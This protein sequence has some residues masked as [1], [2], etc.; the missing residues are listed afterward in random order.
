MKLEIELVPSTVWFSNVRKLVPKTVWDMIRKK[1]YIVASHKCQIC[2]NDGI[3]HCHEIWEYDDEKHI[4]NLKGFVALCENCHMIKHIGF[5][6]Y[7]LE[8]QEKFDKN[9]LIEH[10]CKVNDC[11]IEDFYKHEKEAFKIWHERSKHKWKQDF[12]E[13][14][15]FIKSD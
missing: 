3:L 11:K 6:M 13:Y 15:K 5:S 14:S 8:G 2:G 4:Q 9:E 10:F 1:S 7:T 12:G